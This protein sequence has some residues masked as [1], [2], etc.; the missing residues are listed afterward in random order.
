MLNRVINR[1]VLLLGLAALVCAS[2]V[3]D[4]VRETNEGTAIDFRVAGVTKAQESQSADIDVFYVSARSDG[5][6]NNY[7]TDVPYMRA[8]ND[9]FISS[10]PYYW[11]G[12]SQ[13]QF[14]VYTPSLDDFGQDA[15]LAI[16]AGSQKIRN[17]TIA[18]DLNG[19]KDFLVAEAT[20]SKESQATGVELNFEHK[21]A[22]IEVH[23]KNSNPGYVYSIRGIKIG[24]VASRADFDFNPSAGAS[25][26]IVDPDCDPLEVYEIYGEGKELTTFAQNI[27]GTEGNAMLIPEQLVP[28]DKNTGEG[29]YLAVYAQIKT[30]EG[31]MVYPR[32][33]SEESYGWLLVPLDTE[34]ESGC[35]YVYTLDFSE[36]AGMDENGTDILGGAI[37]FTV[38]ELHWNEQSTVESTAADF[39]GSWELQYVE[40]FREYKPGEEVD[41]NWPPDAVYGPE[42]FGDSGKV[43]S[44]MIRTRVCENN[45]IYLFPGVPGYETECDFRIQ[46]GYLYITPILEDG[47]YGEG[48]SY[49]IRNYS[50]NS[51]AIVS[52]SELSSYYLKKIF[53][54]KKADVDFELLPEDDDD[55]ESLLDG[56]WTLTSVVTTDLSTG[57]VN[58]DTELTLIN[59][60]LKALSIYDN[61]VYL[62]QA[63]SEPYPIENE[64]FVA[65]D[66]LFNIEDVSQSSLR[67]R[68][69]VEELYTMHFN[70][71]RNEN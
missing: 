21:L 37:S 5:H 3:K 61:V 38:Q 52:E 66:Y 12:T 19:Q 8:G 70:Y 49:L 26:W 4:T 33:T 18:S 7:F 34:W 22:Q 53:Y 58:N 23:A 55:A 39:I 59:T 68:L 17:F 41:P 43:P 45:L 6:Q 1:F 25:E 54:Y 28:W 10:M 27:M 50:E 9:M 44:E 15:E 65:Q 35:R 32:P 48:S 51:F 40:S 60:E 71:T 11:P 69:D 67:I 62:N 30:A 56:Q 47:T 24:G 31:A 46:G 29:A 20:A 63:D 2:C 16:G 42:D 36:G 64:S 14:F 13:L 57:E